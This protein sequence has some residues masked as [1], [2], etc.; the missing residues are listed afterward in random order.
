MYSAYNPLREKRIEQITNE[1]ISINKIKNWGKKL[2]KEPAKTLTGTIADLDPTNP[3][4]SVSVSADGLTKALKELD[5]TSTHSS[6]RQ[7]LGRI[8]PNHKLR[9]YLEDHKSEI[10][11]VAAVALGAYGGYFL[12]SKG[13]VT[14]EI[15]AIVATSSGEITVPVMT[16]SATSGGFA[17]GTVGGIGAGAATGVFNSDPNGDIAVVTHPPRGRDPNVTVGANPSAN[18]VTTDTNKGT[19]KTST[20]NAINSSKSIED[21]VTRITNIGNIDSG[22]FKSKIDPNLFLKLQQ[23]VD[24]GELNPLVLKELRVALD[25]LA[26]EIKSKDSPLSSDIDDLADSIAMRNEYGV[27]SPRL[28]ETR[29]LTNQQQSDLIASQIAAGRKFVDERLEDD[30]GKIFRSAGLKFL[31][32]NASSTRKL[33]EFYSESSDLYAYHSKVMLDFTLKFTDFATDFFMYPS[34]AKHLGMITKS[35]AVDGRGLNTEDGIAVGI[36][37]ASIVVPKWLRM[38]SKGKKPAEVLTDVSK[39][40]DKATPSGE[41]IS[42][43]L[44]AGAD[45][46]ASFG[47]RSFGDYQSAK[48]LFTSDPGNMKVFAGNLEM[49]IPKGS[50]GTNIRLYEFSQGG[51]EKAVSDWKKYDFERIISDQPDIKIGKLPN[52]T[53]IIVRIKSSELVPT[54]E[55]QRQRPNGKTEST[56]K[57]R[58]K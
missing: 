31:A 54:L 48:K 8:D 29:K 11:I 46:A 10:A 28:S 27:G 57:I 3:G 45:E 47:F 32:S 30:D 37:F 1:G 26:G 22:L 4:G 43:S 7:M 17:G 41:F 36:D 21:I 9:K 13:Y 38:F 5:V 56:V 25:E 34:I 33:F 39:S 42:N 50:T 19:K 6:F 35:V 18:K 16:I 44:K 15:A 2:L 23:L 55:F 14:G 20:G 49:A 40:I 12:V 51:Y 24:S 58:Y 52:G 53:H